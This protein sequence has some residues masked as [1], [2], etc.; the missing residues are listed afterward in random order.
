MR[1]ETAPSSPVEQQQ[2]IR[3]QSQPLRPPPRSSSYS[4]APQ[5][6][7]RQLPDHERYSL[8]DSGPIAAPVARRVASDSGALPSRERVSGG[9]TPP[10]QRRQHVGVSPPNSASKYATFEEMGIRG[11]GI[12]EVQAEKVDRDCVIM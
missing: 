3:S 6:Q 2:S 11:R 12:A 1:A 5:F 8:V 9:L 7:E 4:N 10:R